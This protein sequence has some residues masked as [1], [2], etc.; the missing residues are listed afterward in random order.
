MGNHVKADSRIYE[1]CSMCSNPDP[2]SC[3][4]PGTLILTPYYLEATSE[5]CVD[6]FLILSIEGR[7]LPDRSFAEFQYLFTSNTS[8]RRTASVPR[9]VPRVDALIDAH[10]E[11]PDKYIIIAPSP[12]VRSTIDLATIR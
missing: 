8:S 10:R 3:I 12:F 11:R 5:D 6:A 7:A 2:V 1:A 4:V 9:S